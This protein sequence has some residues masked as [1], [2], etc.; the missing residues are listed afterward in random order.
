MGDLSRKLQWKAFDQKRWRFE[1][2]AI[3][4]VRQ[5]LAELIRPVL[6]S[7]TPR[8]ALGAVD[9]LQATAMEQAYKD[10]YGR[11]GGQFGSETERTLK[12]QAGQLET[13]SKSTAQWDEFMRNWIALNGV[14]RMTSVTETTIRRLKVAL[15]DAV[16]KGE[17]IQDVARRIVTTG[18]GIADLN[19]ARV[20]ARTE[21]ISASNVGSLQGAL[22]TGLPFVKEWLAT[23]DDR[24]RDAHISADGQR[25][26]QHGQFIVGGEPLEY[27]GSL[28]GSP[29]NVI[30]CRCTT[31]YDTRNLT[32]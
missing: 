26:E 14:E 31:I 11:V 19:R 23:Q 5:G 10:I 18:S 32:P 22:E 7:D 15:Q 4:R 28:N 24:T 6:R 25:T 8:E 16:D 20:I 2:W 21:I 12:S 29:E 3:R 17:G 9:L 13:K 27:P 1:A 30:N